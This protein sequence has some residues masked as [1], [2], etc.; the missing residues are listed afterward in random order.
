MNIVLTDNAKKGFDAARETADE[1][2]KTIQGHIGNA[3]DLT[4][5]VLLAGLGG[6]DATADLPRLLIER[7]ESSENEHIVRLRKLFDRLPRE[8]QLDIETP[9]V[10][11]VD[12]LRKSAEDTVSDVRKTTA[13]AVS[14]VRK[15]AEGAVADVRKSAEGVVERV[16]QVRGEA[17]EGIDRVLGALPSFF[18]AS[19]KEFHG[20]EERVEELGARLDALKKA[21]ARAATPKKKTAP[22]PAAAPKKKAAPKPAAKKT[23]T[24]AAPAPADEPSTPSTD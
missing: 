5:D 14:D 15:T 6:L 17:M 24:P 2:R 23:E 16:D 4:H 22:K 21:R 18:P 1:A 19:Q 8:L 13:D 9:H 12:D 11:S 20:L 3:L 7:G 10:P